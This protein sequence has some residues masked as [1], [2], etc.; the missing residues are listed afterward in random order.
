MTGSASCKVSRCEETAG[1]GAL[2]SVGEEGEVMGFSLKSG[3]VVDGQRTTSA[4]HNLIRSDKLPPFDLS[5]HLQRIYAGF[6]DG[7]GLAGKFA[8]KL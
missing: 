2:P 8:G 7:S 4:S 5:Q 6:F 3:S 1:R